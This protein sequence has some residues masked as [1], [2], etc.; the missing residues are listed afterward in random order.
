MA[1]GMGTVLYQPRGGYF[2]AYRLQGSRKLLKEYF[3]HDKDAERKATARLHEIAM[4]KAKGDK[5]RGSSHLYLDQLAAQ[6]MQDAKVRGAGERW[7]K[8]FWH[9][10]NT[11]ILPNLCSKPVDQLEYADVLGLVGPGMPWAGKSTPTVNRYLG[12]LRAVFRF[13]VAH[14]LTT[15][16]PLAK[17]KK[18]PE[19]K[20][21]VHLTV[22]DLRRII[23]SAEPHLAWALEVEWNLGTRPGKTELFALRWA[24]VDFD[25]PAIHVRGTKTAG[26][27]RIVPIT[28]DFRARLLIVRQEAQSAFLIEYEGRPVKQMARSLKTACRRAGITYPVCMYDVRHLFATVLLN[29][30]ADLAAVSALL[31]HSNVATTQKHYYQLM[32]GEKS[33]AV[34]ML[35]A[36][37][38]PKAGKLVKIK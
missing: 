27:N 5:V 22:A 33:R 1:G 3:G 25:A 2:I 29:E 14:E 24:D 11:Q 13:G 36:I 8:E 34:A 37:A 26:S 7:G 38:E 23:A 28:P 21:D 17:W 20:K 18:T 31:G 35:P 4:F 16:N 10:L 9:L 15:K 12:Y 6:Y 32:R 19:R 30:G